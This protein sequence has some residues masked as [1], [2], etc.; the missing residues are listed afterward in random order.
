MGLFFRQT[1]TL[2]RKNW[3]CRVRQPILCLSEILWPCALFLILA[4]VR[5]QEPP[6]HVKNCYLEP[7]NLP[8]HGIYPFIQSL[9]CNAGS[10]CM[11]TKFLDEKK[12]S[13]WNLSDDFLKIDLAFLKEIEKLS[14][15]ILNMTDQIS[16]LCELWEVFTSKNTSHLEFFFKNLNNLEN[17]VQKMEEMQQQTFLWNLLILPWLNGSVTK[18]NVDLSLLKKN[19]N[20]LENAV[21]KMEE[22][23]QQTFLWNLLILPWLNGSVTKA[24]VPVDILRFMDELLKIAQRKDLAFFLPITGESVIGITDATKALQLEDFISLDLNYAHFWNILL[25]SIHELESMQYMEKQILDFF[26]WHKKTLSVNSELIDE[27]LEL[28]NI[29]KHLPRNEIKNIVKLEMLSEIFYSLQDFPPHLQPHSQQWIEIILQLN[30]TII[31]HLLKYLILRK[32]AIKYL[33][34]I[35]PFLKKVS[36]DQTRINSVVNKI[37]EIF[38]N[39][40]SNLCEDVLEFL[41]INFQLQENMSTRKDITLLFCSYFESF[42]LLNIIDDSEVILDDSNLEMNSLEEQNKGWWKINQLLKENINLTSVLSHSWN[43]EIT[44]ENLLQFRNLSS[45]FQYMGYEIVINPIWEEIAR[46]TTQACTYKPL[47]ESKTRYTSTALAHLCLME[48]YDWTTFVNVS[49]ESLENLKR[50]YSLLLTVPH[51]GKYVNKLFQIN[52]NISK[53]QPKFMKETFTFEELQELQDMGSLN[54]LKALYHQ[55]QKLLSD[56]KYGNLGF[57][58]L[59]FFDDIIQKF[60]DSISVLKPEYQVNYREEYVIL[61]Q[62][63]HKF[64]MLQGFNCSKELKLLQEFFNDTQYNNRT[65]RDEIKIKLRA[66]VI[67]LNDGKNLPIPR[68]LSVQFLEELLFSFL[69]EKYSKPLHL[70]LMRIKNEMEKMENG[71]KNSNIKISSNY[72]RDVKNL[73]TDLLN[74]YLGFI[75]QH[76]IINLNKPQKN[77][78]KNFIK[79]MLYNFYYKMMTSPVNYLDFWKIVVYILQTSHSDFDNQFVYNNLSFSEENLSSEEPLYNVSTGCDEILFNMLTKVTNSSPFGEM[80]HII[81]KNLM[82][83]YNVSEE[84]MEHVLTLTKSC[85]STLTI[86]KLLH[87]LEMYVLKNDDTKYSK[88]MLDFIKTHCRSLDTRSRDSMFNSVLFSNEEMTS[89]YFLAFI[90]Q[91]CIDGTLKNPLSSL[92]KSNLY[93]RGFDTKSLKTMC[94]FLEDVTIPAD[95]DI[96]IQDINVLLLKYVNHFHE[97]LSSETGVEANVTSEHLEPVLFLIVSRYAAQNLNYAKKLCSLLKPTTYNDFKDSKKNI[98]LGIDTS[99]ELTSIS[100]LCKVISKVTDFHVFQRE[101]PDILAMAFNFTHFLLHLGEETIQ[102]SSD[103][104]NMSLIYFLTRQNRTNFVNNKEDLILPENYVLEDILK[105]FLSS[106]N[107]IANLQKILP[108]NTFTILYLIH[109]LMNNQTMDRIENRFQHE[110]LRSILDIFSKE[111]KNAKA[112]MLH[113]LNYIPGSIADGDNYVIENILRL[114][115]ISKEEYDH[116]LDTMFDMLMN[117]LNEAERYKS[118]QFLLYFIKQHYAYKNINPLL[119]QHIIWQLKSHLRDDPEVKQFTKALS[120]FSSWLKVRGVHNE[121]DF[122]Q[123]IFHILHI[124]KVLISTFQLPFKTSQQHVITYF[125]EYLEEGLVNPQNF[126]NYCQTLFE[127]IDLEDIALLQR[128]QSILKRSLSFLSGNPH[129]I[130]EHMCVLCS[131]R[132]ITFSL[133]EAISLFSYQFKEMENTWTLSDDLNCT[134]FILTSKQLFDILLNITSIVQKIRTGAVCLCDTTSEQ[135]HDQIDKLMTNI[136][137]LLPSS[138]MTRLFSNATA[139]TGLR[140]KDILRN[141]SASVSELHTLTNISEK[142]IK[143]VLH[144]EVS[145]LKDLHVIMKSVVSGNCEEHLLQILEYIPGIEATFAV[146]E[147]CAMPTVKFYQFIVHFLQHINFR[148]LV[149]KISFPDEIEK[150]L[151]VVTKQIYNIGEVI[152]KYQDSLNSLLWPHKLVKKMPL[153]AKFLQVLGGGQSEQSVLHFIQLLAST[154][155]NE[156][157]A[158]Y[159]NNKSFKN[160]K[161]IA[162]EDMKKYGIPENSTSFCLKLYCEILQSPNGAFTWAFLKPLLHGKILYAPDVPEIRHLIHKA[163]HTFSLL[164]NLKHYSEAWLTMSVL[165]NSNQLLKKI[166]VTKRLLLNSFLR[167]YVERESKLNVEELVK[168]LQLFESIIG[169]M[170]NGSIIQHLNYFSEF[171]VNMSSCFSFNRFFPLKSSKALEEE[172]KQLIRKN[173]F[174]ASIDFNVST[175]KRSTNKLPAHVKYTIRT[176]ALY[177]MK[178]DKMKNPVW[179][180]H[181]QRLPA[182]GFTYSHVFVPIQDMIDRAIISLQTGTEIFE[183]EVQVQALPYPCHTRDLFLSHIGFF[184]PLIM[185]LAWIISVASMI[186]KQ[187]Y[188]KEIHL[189]EYMKMMGVHA[190][191]N[192]LAWFLEN[193]LVTMITSAI[194][195]LTLKLSGILIHSN[196]AIVFLFML[197]FGISI[198]MFSYMISAFFTNANTAALFGS[199][200]YMII[201]L[202]FI[203]ILVLQKQFNFKIQCLLCLLS[204]TAF[205]QGIFL[206]TSFENEGIGIQWTTLHQPIIHPGAMSFGWTCWMIFIDSILYLMLGWY[207]SNILPGSSGQRKMW[208]F[209]FKYTYWQDVFICGGSLNKTANSGNE[210]IPPSMKRGVAFISVSKIYPKDKMAVKDFSL[211]FYENQITTILGPNGA[212]KTTILSLLDGHCIPTHGKIYV[213]GRDMETERSS[214]RM[215]MGVCPQYDVLFDFLT[216]KEHL[217]LFG[218]LKMPLWSKTQLQQEVK[219]AIK[220]IG[221]SKDHLKYSNTLSGGM[222]RRLSVAI[223]FIG[224]VKTVVLDEPTSGVDPYSRR[225]IWEILLKHKQGRTIIF[226]THNLDETEFLSDQVAIIQEGTLKCCGSQS[227]LKSKYGQG[228]ELTLTKKGELV[229]INEITSLVQEFIPSAILKEDTNKEIVF[230]IPSDMDTTMCKSLFKRLDTCQPDLHISTYGIT[231]TNMEKVFLKLLRNGEDDKAPLGMDLPHKSTDS[232]ETIRSTVINRKLLHGPQHILT[233]MIALIVYR[234]HHTRRDWKG[235]LTIFVLP[236]LFVTMAMEIFTLNSVATDLPPLK[237]SSDLYSDGKALFS[238]DPD[239]SSNFS[240]VL[241]R[242][243]R[244]KNKH[245]CYSRVNLSCWNNLKKQRTT[246]PCK[247]HNSEQDC[248]VFTFLPQSSKKGCALYNLSGHNLEEYLISLA[249]KD[250]YGGWSFTRKLQSIGINKTQAKVWYSQNGFHVLP[251]YLNFLNNVILWKNLP[252]NAD[253]RK[254]AITVYSKPYPGS[255]MDE[256]KIMENVRQCGVA[257][258]ITLG[259]SILISSFGSYIVKDHVSGA[260]VVHHISGLHYRIYW[261]TNFLYDMALYLVPASLCVCVIA[262][263]QLT[264][265]TFRENLAAS[266]LLL[267]LFGYATIPWIYLLAGFFTSSD[268]AFVSY[269]SINFIFGV[270]TMLLTFLPR[271]IAGISKVESLTQ[272]HDVFKW[273]FLIF[274]QFCLG[275]GL[276][277]LAFKQVKYDLDESVGIDSYISPFHL[278]SLG[279]IYITMATEGSILLLLRLIINGFSFKLPG[280]NTS[281]LLNSD[282]M[283]V[284]LE[285]RRLLEGLTA[286]DKLLLYDLR[287]SY[288]NV[289]SKRFFAVK[290]ICLGIQ[291]GECFGLLGLNGAGKSTI[292]KMLT[293]EV[294]PTAGQAMIKTLKGDEVSICSAFNADVTIG[295]CPQKDALNTLLTGWEHLYFYCILRGIP[296]KSIHEVSSALC[297]RLNLNDHIDKLVGTYSRGTKRKLSTAIALIGSPQILLL[298]EPSSG[299]DPCSKRNL[300]KAI[301][302]EIHDGCAVVLTSHSMEECEFL[303]SRL[304]IMVNGLFKCIG[305]PQHIKNRFGEGFMVTILINN[306][307]IACENNASQYFEKLLPGAFLKRHPGLLEYHVSQDRCLAEIFQILDAMKIKNDIKSFTVTQTTLE[308]VFLQLASQQEDNISENEFF[309]GKP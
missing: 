48:N 261:I 17:A 161:E 132:T 68:N 131:P 241:I 140:F 214:I 96:T 12:N 74:E 244:E 210:E 78:Q 162:V 282:D 21:Q 222:K 259:F 208:N 54:L 184:F 183:P 153:L 108:K 176:H 221:L 297:S 265:F 181:P 77:V 185:M 35:A 289:K 200:L 80:L 255:L 45:M 46:I 273:A 279:W 112:L 95:K 271:L 141:G 195:I 127:K 242:K 303:C 23:Q 13:S 280:H 160:L 180:S 98:F 92:H 133:L 109:I 147:I 114:E 301:K 55:L 174:L 79:K 70:H 211:N 230:M 164:E 197:D 283:D 247:F 163:N 29:L 246:N 205:G 83:Y 296:K 294:S 258:C 91:K 20:N 275:Y 53:Q 63:F 240:D 105:V 276:M 189:E 248:Q 49:L 130:I 223:A 145:K 31:K 150:M 272:I 4:A 215:E 254:Y 284:E 15:N 42:H 126:S 148:N 64:T 39:A 207:L 149:Y 167:N 224:N 82:L 231:N 170:L 295:Y 75:L 103:N 120:K 37:T 143:S 99:S 175:K 2:F 157:P 171:I 179:I 232:T 66:Y 56:N 146:R 190:L 107:V 187:V 144:V 168:K 156:K 201:F 30:K 102:H 134:H 264:A 113:F 6:I 3:L 243:F 213:N 305:S 290:N 60:P 119:L 137:K 125:I 26:S 193:I 86:Q 307:D 14:Q 136:E 33:E 192:F 186:R 169:R 8:S 278:D 288:K 118:T 286:N 104:I 152:E 43:T 59:S 110:T 47:H 256:D 36:V 101:Y 72:F 250:S 61:K 229:N 52:V 239:D 237:L 260:K 106:E 88:S 94:E 139:L 173:K 227:I 89:V 263:F 220:N 16:S 84:E 287:K 285:R 178:A 299:M 202:P 291:R 76:H 188:E 93:L 219:Q 165:Q 28:F 11:D 138:A 209:L 40:N 306:K 172:A 116:M 204:T 216:V 1:G 71:L 281:L 234:V 81:N 251:S 226:T 128:L 274:P 270:S 100:I 62:L 22:M 87:K 293:G 269:V 142:T 267:I 51:I 151:N 304:A 57:H 198:I 218:S 44:N 228:Y 90:L 69:V 257:L 235:A 196:W 67:C 298:D 10:R 111:F 233:Q 292:F 277:E 5:F 9:I 238:L 65:N 25:Q 199:L 155:C 121:N 50:L 24:N 266:A 97:D 253:W 203:V 308:Q 191:T 245:C 19:L 182:S 32:E 252:S 41:Q 206:I 122:K 18:P 249:F 302:E 123:L 217:L 158:F 262:S 268:V 194:I 309:S 129:L 212:G 225:R 154:F 7:R 34:A 124:T 27:R 58:W 115:N 135:G 38:L 300:W 159:S 177:S 73:T 117:L 236:I 85:F 166:K